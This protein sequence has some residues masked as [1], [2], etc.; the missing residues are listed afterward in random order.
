MEE[1]P[2]RHQYSAYHRLVRADGIGEWG[3]VLQEILEGSSAHCLVKDAAECEKRE[4]IQHRL[5]SES[6]QEY[7]VE[8]LKNTLEALGIAFEMPRRLKGKTWFSLFTLLRNKTKGHGAKKPGVLATAALHL[9]ESIRHF[10]E[11]FSL[12]KR[13][14]AYLRQNLSGKYRVVPLAQDIPNLKKL[15]KRAILSSHPNL[16]EGVYILFER[17][18]RVK[19]LASDVDISDVWI[20]NGSFS[21]KSFEMLSYI[22]GATR[23]EDARPYL[24]PTVELPASETQGLGSLDVQ[25]NGFGNLPPPPDSYIKRPKLESEL[26]RRLQEDHHPIVTLHGRGGIGKTYLALHVV[27]ELSQ[28]TERFEIY[29]WFSARDIDLLPHGPKPVKPSEI[30][31]V[32]FANQYHALLR[33]QPAK[34]Q[35][36][37]TTFAAE[38]AAAEIGSTLFIFDNFET[39]KNPAEVYEWLDTYIRPPN[40]ALITTRYRDFRGDFPV[41][42]RGMEEQEFRELIWTAA[43]PLGIKSLLAES[44]IEQ[45]Y[46]ESDGHPYVGKVLL[47]EVAREGHTV[48]PKRVMAGKDG[49]LTALFER[50]FSRL[51]SGA[52]RVFLTIASWRS[53]IPRVALEAVLLRPANE[54]RIDVESALQ[55]LTQSSFIESLISSTDEQEFLVAPLVA[56]VF[57][58]KKLR[59]S[60][61]KAA[62]EA[63]LIMLR[64][65]GVGQVSDVKSGIGPRIRK[66]AGTLSRKMERDSLPLESYR[67]VLRF[68]ASKH[69]PTWLLIADL[70]LEAG[71]PNNIEN[72]RHATEQFIEAVAKDETTKRQ[73][74]WRRMIHIARRRENIREQIHAHAELAQ[75][76]GVPF[77]EIS[78]AAQVVNELMMDAR[79]S[80]EEDELPILVSKLAAIMAQRLDEANATDC[81]RLAWLHLHIQREDEARRYTEAGLARDLR[82][83]HC[84]RL[85]E[86][87]G[88][89]L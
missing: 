67:P 24:G 46:I 76:E 82:N 21:P 85:A 70:E 10:S 69:P 26:L 63:D 47:G 81:S 5:P 2:D 1:D 27:H 38:L 45:L 52:Q 57:G 35:E 36:K 66:L 62:I 42:V 86:R 71:H 59:S 6:W 80:L 51:S 15:E 20:P 65:F 78:D 44:Y 83:R 23:H 56:Q 53:T 39:V 40:K 68:I 87:L 13:E 41:S 74:G 28:F 64:E 75:L 84:Q 77:Y 61:W 19:L 89:Q 18:R 31:V 60:P 37:V 43:A 73:E 25:G 34:S 16:A 32:D 79:D 8:E 55:E 50:T 7:A 22:S 33:D 14:W 29:V 12:F 30:D 9:Q 54:E 58:Q 72:A 4:L 88:I 48:T 3:S 49:I 17:P 11:G